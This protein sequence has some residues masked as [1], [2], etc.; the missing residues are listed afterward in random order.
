LTPRQATD[1]LPGKQTVSS[2]H[3]LTWVNW[4]ISGWSACYN[5]YKSV[6]F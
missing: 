3:I 2:Q 4:N 5:R 6:S 1:K